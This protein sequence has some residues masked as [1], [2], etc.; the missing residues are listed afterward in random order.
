M[1][2]DLQGVADVHDLHIWTLDSSTA[3]MSVHIVADDPP[4]ALRAAQNVCKANKIEH[5]TIQVELCGS[6]DVTHCANVNKGCSAH[7][8]VPRPPRWTNPALQH[9]HGNKEKQAV[10]LISQP[11]AQG[12]PVLG[13]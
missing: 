8:Y 5:S 2:L 12:V 3:S 7:G 4:R 13:T 11:L 9:G 10:P 1:L 6:D